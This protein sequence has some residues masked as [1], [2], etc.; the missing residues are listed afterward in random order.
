MKKN[1]VDGTVVH[2]NTE[3]AV[4]ADGRIKPLRPVALPFATYVHTNDPFGHTVFLARTPF[5]SYGYVD[6]T[7][8]PSVLSRSSCGY[9]GQSDLYYRHIAVFDNGKT[10]K[11]ALL[12]IVRAMSRSENRR[13]YVEF[14]FGTGP[15]G[16]Q[17]WVAGKSFLPEFTAPPQNEESAS[18]Q[19]EAVLYIGKELSTSHIHRFVSID[20]WS[21]PTGPFWRIDDS[22]LATSPQPKEV[23][24]I[25][26]SYN[27]P[28]VAIHKSMV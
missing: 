14:G 27:P 17:V 18:L 8:L 22:V 21:S 16:G 19:H 2:V 26:F 3:G 9:G 13:V 15:R 11:K 7:G 5:A 10:W 20:K 28:T 12:D 1:G 25:Y 6:I 24:E 4:S 23:F